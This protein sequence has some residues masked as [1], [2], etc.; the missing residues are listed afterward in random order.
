MRTARKKLDQNPSNLEN[1]KGWQAEPMKRNG[2][3][4]T[5]GRNK[6]AL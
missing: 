1:L 3:I 4:F 6:I 2:D 5:Q